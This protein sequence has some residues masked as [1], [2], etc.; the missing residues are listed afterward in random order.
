LCAGHRA[1]EIGKTGGAMSGAGA[2]MARW[3]WHALSEWFSWS[4][5]ARGRL[6]KYI[7][8]GGAKCPVCRLELGNAH[9]MRKGLQHHGFGKGEKNGAVHADRPIGL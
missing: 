4:C 1:F 8:P 7:L 2:N 5:K 3:F 9:L 6:K